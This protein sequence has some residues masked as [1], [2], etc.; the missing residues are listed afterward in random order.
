MEERN[1]EEVRQ[2]MGKCV[3]VSLISQYTNENVRFM[4]WIFDKRK[5]L[6]VW[7]IVPW[8]VGD[9]YLDFQ[10][11]GNNTRCLELRNLRKGVLYSITVEDD[12][13]PILLCCLTFAIFYRYTS[14]RKTARKIF[15]K[16]NSQGTP[17]VEAKEG[18]RQEERLIA[19][20]YLLSN[21]TYDAM[22]IYPSHLFILNG[23]NMT[24]NFVKNLCQFLSG[25]KQTVE[26][27]RQ[28]SGQKVYKGKFTM[29]FEAYC[30]MCDLIVCGV[31]NEYLFVHCFLNLDWNIMS[32]SNNIASCIINHI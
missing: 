22:T 20:K 10:T 3:V 2:I 7:L 28:G 5:P 31:Q 29:P 16:R 21:Y 19:E 27:Q 6:K 15:G 17:P 1:T 14:L 25:M 8:M 9:L 13:C 24:V 4:M 18:S 26:K 23:E 11:E 30:F 12:N 32:K